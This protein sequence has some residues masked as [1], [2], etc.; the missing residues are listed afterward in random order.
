M[1][2]TLNFGAV[3]RGFDDLLAGLLLGLE[4]GLGGLLIGSLIGIVAALAAV[5][6]GRPARILV[7][8]Y[9]GLIRNVPILVLALF[10]F[11]AL[12]S[13]GIRFDN[14]ITFAAVLAVYAGAY[15]T[16]S[17]RAA[18]QVIPKGITEAAQSIGLTRTGTAIW[19]ILPIALRNALPS[20]GNNFIS[21]FKDTSIAAV[22]AVP[23]LT[24]QA[25]KINNESFRVIEVWMIASLMYVFTCALIA[26]GLRR[27]EAAFPKF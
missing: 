6:G 26:T 21:L 9:V 27:L 14:V 10:A 8:L 24:F 7:A 11:F 19:V 15:L 16:E 3:F 12:P 4:M 13:I 2:Y 25:R 17:F 22:I 18:I 20:V 23:E 1:D 5:Y